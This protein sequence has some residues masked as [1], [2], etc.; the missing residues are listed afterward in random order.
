AMSTTTV[1]GN[2][3][4]DAETSNNF[5]IGAR[6]NP[7]ALSLD[8]AAFYSVSDDYIAQVLVDTNSGSE[9]Y[10]YQNVSKAT[11]FGTEFVASYTF[12][13]EYG[14]VTPY[15]SATWMRRE[16]DNGEGFKT[17]NT[18]TP[19]L[20]GRYGVRWAKSVSPLCDVRVDLYGRSQTAMKYDYTPASGEESLRYGGFTTANLSAGFD[21]GAEKQ[22][23]IVAE[24]L[25]IF[26][27][28]YTYASSILE[29]GVHAN[30]KFSMKF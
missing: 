8:V 14:K 23:T 21:F 25:N 20:A 2:P 9:T 11:S 6:W 17:Y 16:Y 13:T 3:D 4:L 24:L 1:M 15:A 26:D 22:Y 28:R 5:E 10:Q 30:L 18:G 27:K 19:T 7:G 12:D 29:P